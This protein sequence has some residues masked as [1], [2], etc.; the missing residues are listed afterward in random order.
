MT[1]SYRH[2]TFEERCQVKT[3]RKS[4]L[5]KG[6]IAQH[7][8]GTGVKFDSTST[9]E[10]RINVPLHD[11]LQQQCNILIFCGGNFSAAADHPQFNP[12]GQRCLQPESPGK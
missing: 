4:G 9:L 3:S 11:C 7:P 8:T 2:L 5:S 12:P 1:R 10:F 6:S